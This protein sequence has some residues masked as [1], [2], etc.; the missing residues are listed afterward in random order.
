MVLTTYK[1]NR[2]SCSPDGNIR[3][4]LIRLCI[5][6]I[7]AAGVLLLFTQSASLLYEGAISDYNCFVFMSRAWADGHIPYVDFVDNKGPLL[8]LIN[9]LGL[10]LGP[11][12][13]GI[14]V[15]E[16]IAFVLTFELLW[17]TGR[18]FGTSTKLNSLGALLAVFLYAYFLVEGNTTE[19]WSMPIIALVL[20]MTAKILRMGIP[21][22]FDSGHIVL[23]S[24]LS[25]VCLGL[26]TMI[27]PGNGT[28]I[29]GAAI[30]IT[31]EIGRQRCWKQLL[32][33]TSFFLIG[34]AASVLPFV[35][36]FA[37]NGAL[38]AMVYAMIEMNLNYM[39]SFD[40]GGSTAERLFS[41]IMQMSACIVLPLVAY[42]SDRRT[43]SRFFVTMLAMSALTLLVFVCASGWMHYF[44]LTVPLAW[45]A[46]ALSKNFGQWAR[47][48]VVAG[49]VLPVMTIHPAALGW[50]VYNTYNNINVCSPAQATFRQS[51]LIKK[52]VPESQRDSIYIAMGAGEVACLENLGVRPIGRY[53]GMQSMVLAMGGKA[54]ADI[55]LSFRQVCPRWFFSWEPIEKYPG[56]DGIFNYELVD[57]IPP[58]DFGYTAR[59]YRRVWP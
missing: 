37:Y 25:G 45:L 56:I 32:R 3:N 13:T 42:F 23:F 43:G 17:R 35:A 16:F 28:I 2:L 39:T 18:E 24:F 12:K 55:V 36:W 33:C 50:Y 30:G 21:R 26:V 38:D 51:K 14:F 31:F 7:L 22:R 48:A 52:H 40:P 10:W 4:T 29:A 1:S 6:A 11:G 27:R 57:S 9:R 34:L 54:S 59:L 46:I 20:Y 58:S 44:L 5:F 47:V 53:F 41:S 49:I 19:E 8:Y 15:L